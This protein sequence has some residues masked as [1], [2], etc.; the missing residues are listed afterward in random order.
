MIDLIPGAD[1]AGIPGPEWLFHILLVLTFF[2]HLLFMNLTLGG[3]ILGFVAHAG[4]R[5]GRKGEPKAELARR[6][7]GVNTY[8]ISLTITTGVAPLLFIQVLYHGFFYSATILIAG[9]WFSFLVLLMVGYYATYLYKMR[10]APARGRGGGWWLLLSAVM[11]FAVAMVQVSVQ[12]G[13]ARPDIW[14]G[15]AANPWT[16]LGDPTFVPRL[17]HFVLAGLGVSAALMAFWAVRQAKRGIDVDTNTAIAAYTWRWVLWTTV[18]QVVDGF[19]LLLLLPREVLIGLMTS[20]A[21]TLIPLTLAILLGIG[22]L[23]MIARTTDPAQAPALV[24][25]VLGAMVITTAVMAIT[26]HQVRTLYLAP[27]TAGIEHPVVAQ[28]GNFFLFAVLLLAGL[29][30]VAWMV[31]NTLNSP[32]SGEEAA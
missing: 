1:P 32:A 17:L 21:G 20:G 22:L 18:L 9:A 4:S 27:S 10:G 12:I 6:L 23:V 3:S 15:L 28:W 19:V 11:F 7:V 30:T 31:R 14:T 8:G 24:N 16:V 2:L 5:E 29:A 25:G 26:R 13:H